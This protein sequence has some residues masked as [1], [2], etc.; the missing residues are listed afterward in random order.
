MQ[1]NDGRSRRGLGSS[2][3]RTASLALAHQ[4]LS[5]LLRDS[6]QPTLPPG[7]Q[8]RWRK[9]YA[10]AMAKFEVPPSSAEEHLIRV[11]ACAAWARA[12]AVRE[13][14]RFGYF[15]KRFQDRNQD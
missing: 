8:S 4:A 3:G 13:R 2:A 1:T 11:D 5:E 6:H 7:I 12:E 10:E 15:L 9:L 14:R